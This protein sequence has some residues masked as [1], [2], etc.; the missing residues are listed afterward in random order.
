ML[1]VFAGK[2]AV[3][4]RQAAHKKIGELNKQ[5]DEVERIDADS[6]M[7]NIV[8]D[9]I[10]SSSLFGGSQIVL[11]D[12]PQSDEDLIDEVEKNLKEIG[13]SDNTFVVIEGVVKAPLKK[14]Y[15]KHGEFIEVETKEEKSTYNVFAFTDALLAKDKKQLWLLLQESEGVPRE[16]IIG[17]LFWQ[18]KILRLAE[19]TSSPEEAGQKPFV[20]NKAK[21]AL[22]K[23]K[24]G[25]VDALSRSLIEIYHKAHQGEGDMEVMFEEWTLSL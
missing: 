7:P 10:E 13:Q 3:Q 14:K 20:Y 5:N 9:A 1:F 8:V 11:I 2:D 25:E 4:V 19:R 16:E 17:V 21:R 24:E 18:I 23:F 12:E 15:Q 6:Y 22:S